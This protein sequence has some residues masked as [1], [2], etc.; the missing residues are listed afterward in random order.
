MVLNKPHHPLGLEPSNFDILNLYGPVIWFLHFVSDP[1]V[2]L[3]SV[4]HL[5]DSMLLEKD[6]LQQCLDNHR[7]SY[8]RS[9][10]RGKAS[11]GRV[12]SKVAGFHSCVHSLDL[13]LQ[14][15]LTR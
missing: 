15:T 6:V 10:S 4:Q 7:P 3:H 5:H 11:R 8:A 1:F 2:T 9:P 14:S 12:F 13:R